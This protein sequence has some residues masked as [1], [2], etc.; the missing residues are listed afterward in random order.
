M[1][2]SLGHP[3]IAIITQKVSGKFYKERTRKKKGV[4]GVPPLGCL[5]FWGREGGTLINY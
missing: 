3:H 1:L 5:P 2:P 4:K